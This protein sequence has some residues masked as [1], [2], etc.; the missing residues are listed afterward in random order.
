MNKMNTPKK[1]VR[2]ILL[3]WVSPGITLYNVNISEHQF[4]RHVLKCTY[5]WP[6]Q[7]DDSFSVVFGR[8]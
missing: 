4:E 5:S 1:Q 3:L 6:I 8:Y 2:I 7:F